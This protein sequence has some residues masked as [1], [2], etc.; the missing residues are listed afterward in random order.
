MEALQSGSNQITK[1]AEAELGQAQIK[2]E[3]GFTLIKIWL[4]K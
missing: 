1:Q 4:V 2:L 3:L